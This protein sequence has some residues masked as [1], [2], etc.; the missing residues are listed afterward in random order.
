M[1]IKKIPTVKKSSSVTGGATTPTL[2]KKGATIPPKT[3]PKPKPKD[4]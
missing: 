3:K 1:A 4:K 2:I